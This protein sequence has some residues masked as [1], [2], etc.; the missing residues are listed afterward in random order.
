MVKVVLKQEHENVMVH[1]PKENRKMSGP[2]IIK[3]HAPNQ[4]NMDKVEMECGPIGVTGVRA[5]V[6]VKKLLEIDGEIA[7]L[8]GI[9]VMEPLKKLSHVQCITVTQIN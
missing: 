8:V 1:A 4:I 7:N 9:S 3:R 2:V 6:R 5:L